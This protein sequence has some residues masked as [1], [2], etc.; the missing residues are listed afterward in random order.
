VKALT[1]RKEGEEECFDM[2]GINEYE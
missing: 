2:F 1:R